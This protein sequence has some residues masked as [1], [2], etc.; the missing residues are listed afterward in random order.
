MWKLFYIDMVANGRE[1]VPNILS[2][3]ALVCCMFAKLLVVESQKI[4][5]AN[6][7]CV[8]NSQH[9]T[10]LLVILFCCSC[11]C[12]YPEGLFKYTSND[13]DEHENI[14]TFEFLFSRAVYCNSRPVYIM[15]YG[16]TNVESCGKTTVDTMHCVPLA[17]VVF[18]AYIA[19]QGGSKDK[20]QPMWDGTVEYTRIIKDIGMEWKKHVYDDVKLWCTFRNNFIIRIRLLQ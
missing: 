15:S 16:W 1:A 10:Y 17:T 19:Y 13:I 4:V 2:S 5:T 20:C 12:V 9:C 14:F 18:H 6:N 11:Y 7:I 3:N 8:I